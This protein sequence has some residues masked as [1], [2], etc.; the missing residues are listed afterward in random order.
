MLRTVIAI[1]FLSFVGSGAFAQDFG[2][3]LKAAQGGDYATAVK[4]WRPLAELGYAVAQNNLGVMYAYGTGVLKDATEA[5][6]WYRLAAEQGYASAQYNLGNMY[7]NGR[8]VL[9][10]ATEAVLWYRLAAEQG[11][12]SAQ[13]NL[14]LMYDTGKGVLKDFVAAH[15]WYNIAAANGSEKGAKNRDLIEKDMTRE[16]IAEATRWAKTCMASDYAD[17]D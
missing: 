10:D 3:G 9:K 5:A 13:G 15:M 8:G 12:A 1:I 16:Q 2:K 6:R 7:A 11:H 14:G 4:E 17:C